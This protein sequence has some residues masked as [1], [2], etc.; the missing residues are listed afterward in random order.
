MPV[1]PVTNT[2]ALNQSQLDAKKKQQKGTGFT[3]INRVLDANKGAGERMG[4]KIG[5]QLTQQADSV[6]A[7]IQSSQNQFQQQKNQAGQAAQQN[8]QAG[9]ALVKQAGET[10]DAY[11]ARLAQNQDNFG[12]IG[13]NLKSAE[14]Q[15]PMA[16]ENAGKLQAQASSAAALGKLGRNTE[17]QTELLKSL[18]ARPGEYNRGQSALDALLLGQTGQKAIQEGR[19]ASVGLQDM[20]FNKAAG[21]EKQAQALK[22]GIASSRDKAL[23]DLQGAVTGDKGFLAQAQKQAQQYQTDATDLANIMAGQFDTSTPEGAARAQELVNRMSDFGLEDYNLYSQDPNAAKSALSQL[24]STLTHQFGGKKF[25]DDQSL[26]S[27]NLATL[28]GDSQL[29]D[30]IASNKFNTDVFGKET[31]AFR[32]LD[33]ERTKDISNRD[34][35]NTAA[36]DFKKNEEIA[37]QYMAEHPGSLFNL[38]DG[39][40]VPQEILDKYGY[41]AWGDVN[42]DSDPRG[43][44]ALWGGLG[45]TGDPTRAGRARSSQSL[46]DAAQKQVGEDT[47]MKDFILK[48]ILGMQG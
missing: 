17:G 6:R 4:Q 25:T 7:G 47:K 13:Q 35:L 40:Y 21:A 16:L 5:G 32:G 19:R 8:V 26:A 48:Q 41:F 34:R 23:A 38:N 24:G 28:L 43:K 3:N 42:P 11:A 15:G 33:A 36:A 30:Q 46:F 10:D 37:Q 20:A 39:G 1:P 2:A 12:Q 18:V 22:S 31:D 29:K 45:L 9:Q 14:Y 44:D 27:Q